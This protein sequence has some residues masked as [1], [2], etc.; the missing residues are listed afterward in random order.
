MAER[1]TGYSVQLAKSRRF[2]LEV[3]KSR[4]FDTSKYQG[5]SI[6]AAH[7]MYLNAQLDMLVVHPETGK[8]V[9]VRYHDSKALRAANITDYVETYF[10]FGL[11]DLVLGKSDDLIIIT[12]DPANDSL[13]K[14]VS[15]VWAQSSAFISI[16]GVSMLQFNLL[17]HQLVPPH[18]VL[19][20]AEALIVKETHGIRTDLQIPGM[21]RFDPVALLL[22]VRPGQLCE[23]TRPSRTAVTSKF[24]RICSQ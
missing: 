8:K 12:K 16:I 1:I 2:I 18:R 14:A 17:D 21:S 6:S 3:L 15:Q 4:G 13:K 10:G 22:G 9:Y 19:S 5:F 23:I 11:A 7:E 20:E 24:W